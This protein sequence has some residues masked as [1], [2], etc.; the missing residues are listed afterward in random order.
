MRVLET[1]SPALVSAPSA[2]GPG[3]VLSVSLPAL[4]HQAGERAAFPS[5]EFF[6]TR[7][8][9]LNTRTAYCR[10]ARARANELVGPRY[11][12]TGQ[13]PLDTISCAD[14]IC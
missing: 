7:I 1:D 11:A 6:A 9:N 2:P 5:A 8:P 14:H 13:Y 3:W 12:A 4:V 10:A